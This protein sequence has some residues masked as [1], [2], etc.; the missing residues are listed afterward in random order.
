[1]NAIW[2]LEREVKG[3]EDR[4]LLFAF[5]F[6]ELEFDRAVVEI[7]QEENIVQSVL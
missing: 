1:M 5:L 6:S 7:F 3:F 4:H 2:L